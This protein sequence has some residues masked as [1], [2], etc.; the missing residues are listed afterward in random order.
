M[1]KR[2][3]E[4]LQAARE[5]SLKRRKLM[6]E[7]MS[8]DYRARQKESFAEKKIIADLNKSQRACEQLDSAK[9]LCDT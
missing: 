7:R 9:V 3:Q 6:E 5:E 1:L 4:T 8:G 2:K